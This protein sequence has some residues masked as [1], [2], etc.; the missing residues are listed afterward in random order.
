MLRDI[1]SIS[2]DS[3]QFYCHR[4]KERDLWIE[5][6]RKAISGTP[7]P[8]GLCRVEERIPPVEEDIELNE[9]SD[10]EEVIK[11]KICV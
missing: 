10:F 3:E 2:I 7:E 6:L 4:R 5:H 9:E 1:F 8:L 11:V